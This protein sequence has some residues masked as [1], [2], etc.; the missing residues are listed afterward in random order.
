MQF[1][2]FRDLIHEELR[3]NPSGRTW[4]ELKDQL[5]LPYERPCP[6]WVRRL[7]QEIGLV[8]TKRS[9]AALFWTIADGRA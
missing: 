5:Q 8:R 1:V 7:E 4:A 6:T 2:E 3:R 9:G